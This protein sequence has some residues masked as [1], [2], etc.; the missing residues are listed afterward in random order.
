MWTARHHMCDRPEWAD[1]RSA[2]PHGRTAE[3]RPPH[4]SHAITSGV[5]SSRL[6]V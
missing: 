2:D 5:A 4:A 6:R 3:E 1:Q